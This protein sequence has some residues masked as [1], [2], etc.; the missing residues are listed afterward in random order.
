M[1][2]PMECDLALVLRS[3]R[4]NWSVPFT[5]RDFHPAD[6]DTLWHIDLHCFPSGISYSRAE[7]K[8]YMRRP[9]AFTLVAENRS[10]VST[11]DPASGKRGE[12]SSPLSPNETS[13]ARAATAGFI[14]AEA[15]RAS[16]HIITI[17]VI[18]SVRRAGLGSLLLKAAEER[19]R[20]ASC[21]SVGLE[22]AVDNLSALAFYKRHAYSVVRTHPRYYSNG[23]DA[24]VLEKDLDR[25]S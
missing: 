4:Y 16:G 24:F 10:A 20:A 3:A 18:A 25:A 6:F 7:L 23:V 9:G 19:L 1:K 8:Y 13:E 5:I 14:V 12:D 17:D 22:T 21:R 2:E 15:N 11:A